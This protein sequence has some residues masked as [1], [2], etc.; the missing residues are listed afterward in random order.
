MT[1]GTERQAPETAATDPAQ[2]GAGTQVIDTREGFSEA[3]LAALEACAEAGVKQLWLC[4]P[5]FARWPLG[6][7][8]VI[9]ALIRWANSRRRL[10]LLAA[11]YGGFAQRFPR[12][13]AWRR[14]WSHIVQCLAVHEELADKL[15]TL[16]FAP[17]LV[18]VRLHDGERY[19][20]RVYREQADLVQCRELIEALSQRADESFPVTTLGL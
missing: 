6:Q 5:D 11:D 1:E 19:R 12:W 9:E 18:A 3:L 4:D 10:T 20:G 7:P 14:Q 8:A 16:L 17:E 13:V 15:P 2:A